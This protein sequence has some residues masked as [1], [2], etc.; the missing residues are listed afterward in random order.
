MDTHQCIETSNSIDLTPQE[1]NDCT[2]NDI[3]ANIER[4]GADAETN[5]DLTETDQSKDR[6]ADVELASDVRA[7]I[8]KCALLEHGGGRGSEGKGSNEERSEMHNRLYVYLSIY[9]R[10]GCQQ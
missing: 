4:Q 8:Q 5:V 7:D 3:G 9:A 6:K 2:T 10:V 1:L